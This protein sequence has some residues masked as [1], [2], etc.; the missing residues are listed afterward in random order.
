ML[1]VQ[2]PEENLRSCIILL[3]LLVVVV[4]TVLNII[5]CTSTSSA[6]LKII[7]HS[8]IF[9]FA[10][11]ISNVIFIEISK[12][13]GSYAAAVIFAIFCILAFRKKTKTKFSFY[14][15]NLAINVRAAAPIKDST[16]HSGYKDNQKTVLISGVSLYPECLFM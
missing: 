14:S 4:P 10:K 11:N 5:R 3:L 9:F 15:P 13:N 2:F 8:R 6:C 1:I 12:Q 16:V 7:F